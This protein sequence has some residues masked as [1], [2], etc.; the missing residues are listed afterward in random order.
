MIQLC[1]KSHWKKH[2]SWIKFNIKFESR[3]KTCPLQ[4]DGEYICLKLHNSEITGSQTGVQKNSDKI[5]NVT[6]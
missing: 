3:Q 1:G 4:W 2:F 5:Y 6:T